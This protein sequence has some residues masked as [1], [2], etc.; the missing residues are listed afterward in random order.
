[1]L[2]AGRLRVRFP[3][4][5]SRFFT[6]PNPSSRTMALGSTQPLTEM[7]TRNVPGGKER[8]ARGADNLTAR[9]R[10]AT[11]VFRGPLRQ[12][13]LAHFYP[14]DLGNMFLRN[15][16]INVPT[17]RGHNPE[18]RNMDLYEI[19]YIIPSSQ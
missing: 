16:G 13:N 3:N 1:M 7:S 10:L 5:V 11:P 15:V 9:V 19:P 14:Q 4:E 6:L 17:T 2:Q 18:D 12:Y 8:P